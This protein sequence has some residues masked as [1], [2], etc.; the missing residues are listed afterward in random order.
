[1]AALQRGIPGYAEGDSDTGGF[2][3]LLRGYGQ[4]ITNILPG[5]TSQPVTGFAQARDNPASSPLTSTLGQFADYVTRNIRA[6]NA[7]AVGPTGLEWTKN[8]FAG[9][10]DSTKALQDRA[11]AS[12]QLSDPLVQQYLTTNPDQLSIAER[13]PRGYGAVSTDPNFRAKMALAVGA[14]EDAAANDRVTQA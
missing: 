1:M 14:H 9:D 2:G 7:A 10:R 4:A 13:D 8:L 6:Q 11:T 3:Q 5:M 12:Q